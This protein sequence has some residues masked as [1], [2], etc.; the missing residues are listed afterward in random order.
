MI[1]KILKFTLYAA[2]LVAVLAVAAFFTLKKMY[3][4]EK[5]KQMTQTWVAQHWN[6]EVRFS[7]VSFTWIGFT[8]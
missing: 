1:Q 4:P 6:R 8:L 2:L 3:P 5:L 7:E